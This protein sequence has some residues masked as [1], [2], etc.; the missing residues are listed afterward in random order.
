MVLF[1]VRLGVPPNVV[2]A[3]GNSPLHKAVVLGDANVDALKALIHA[4]KG[5]VVPGRAIS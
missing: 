5:T 4:A 3:F 2:D 1:A